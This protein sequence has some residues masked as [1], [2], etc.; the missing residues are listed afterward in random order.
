MPAD[1]LNQLAEGFALGVERNVGQFF[2]YRSGT[3][4]QFV[5]RDVDAD[6]PNWYDIFKDYTMICEL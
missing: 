3:F 6:D 2:G 5:P 1:L 4:P